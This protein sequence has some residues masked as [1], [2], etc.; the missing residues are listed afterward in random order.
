MVLNGRHEPPFLPP[1]EPGPHAMAPTVSRNSG[2]SAGGGCPHAP[3]PATPALGR[4]GA[5]EA[6]RG[7][8]S[9]PTTSCKT[10]SGPCQHTG[11]EPHLSPDRYSAPCWGERALIPNAIYMEHGAP[12]HVQRAC[13]TNGSQNEM[14]RHRRS[15]SARSDTHSPTSQRRATSPTK[16][17]VGPRDML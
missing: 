13:T 1:S 17:M 16:S 9:W 2:A 6:S 14:T 7:S 10:N 8:V 4:S 3:H 15:E 12:R 11:A 5:L